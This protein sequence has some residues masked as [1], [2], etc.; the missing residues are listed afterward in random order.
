VRKQWSQAELET[1]ER[2]AGDQPWSLATAAY[3]LW[4]SAHGYP[5]RSPHALRFAA[6]SHGL[7]IVSEGQWIRLSVLRQALGLSIT[8]TDR[9]RAKGILRVHAEGPGRHYISRTEIRRLARRRPDLFAG[10]DPSHLA[11]LLDPDAYRDQRLIEDLASRP[12]AYRHGRPRPVI[13]LTTG[14][15]FPSAEAAGQAVFV[16]SPAIRQAILR[17]TPSAGKHWGWLDE[18]QARLMAPIPMALD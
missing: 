12:V 9:L 16:T 8:V 13:C 1:L 11:I 10:V 7:S 5:R 17:R 4:A 2:L 14:E 3:G 6:S 18:V 15:R